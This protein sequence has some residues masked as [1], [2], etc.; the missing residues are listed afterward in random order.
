RG[1]STA[2]VEGAMATLAPIV[3]VID[4]DMQHDERII[5]A[6]VDAI[7]TGGADVALGSRYCEAGSVG[8]WAGHRAAGSRL[9][10]WLT[11]TLL[12]TQ[13]SDPMSGFF[14]FRKDVLVA[15][16][17]HLSSMGFKILLDLLASSPTPL[18]VKE[19]P[20]EFRSRHAGASK[21]DS[22][23][24]VDFIL[25]LLDKKIGRLVPPRFIMFGGI[26]A[27]G[28]IVH[29]AMLKLGLALIGSRM[30]PVEAFVP[31]NILG[32]SSAIAFNFWLNNNLTYRDKRLHGWAAL[33]GLALFYIVCGLGAIANVGAGDYVF[34]RDHNTLLAVFSGSI[35]GSVWN[36]AVSSATTWRRR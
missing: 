21:L 4:A 22:T 29:W 28:M 35:V 31:A 17:P 12:K 8:A 3:V 7:C 11:H 25:L 10:T 26:G 23:V 9:A 27:L 19:I 33:K 14:A 24:A 16:L 18:R 20:Y 1:L 5:P 6:L 30:P 2:V 15:A 32:V 34:G 13:V 36:Y